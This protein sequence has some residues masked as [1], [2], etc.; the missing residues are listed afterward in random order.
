MGAHTASGHLPGRTATATAGI[1]AAVVTT[2]TTGVLTGGTALATDGH[3]GHVHSHD[4]GHSR[5]EHRDV[6]QVDEEQVSDPGHG[7]AEQT[8]CEVLGDVDLGGSCST[9]GQQTSQHSSTRESDDQNSGHP[10]SGLLGSAF[11]GRSGPQARTPQTHRTAPAPQPA[12][13]PAPKPTSSV[14]DKPTV[15]PI[16]AQPSA[17]KITP[18][19]A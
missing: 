13:K 1:A 5:S 6:T 4:G 15:Q 14:P 10:S 8:L 12:A 17:N 3:G 18:M 2:A 11:P 16:T 19:G 9:D 7:L